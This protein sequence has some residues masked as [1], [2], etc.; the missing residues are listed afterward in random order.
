MSRASRRAPAG[1][2]CFR[3]PMASHRCWSVEMKRKLGRGL[4]SEGTAILIFIV[5]GFMSHR[6]GK[7][8]FRK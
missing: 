5:V 2:R 3:N 6:K 4:L 1:D 8:K 7:E